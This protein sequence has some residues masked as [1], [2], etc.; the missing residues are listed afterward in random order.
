[1]ERK[2][3]RDNFGT[4]RLMRYGGGLEASFFSLAE[5]E[6]QGLGE[7]GTLP[8]CIKV[9]LE[10][11][12]RN[13]DGVQVTPEHVMGLAKWGLSGPWGEIP[14]MPA[15]VVLQDFTGVP[16]LVDLAAMREA[17]KEMG[18]DPARINPRIPCD[19]VIDHSVQVDYFNRPDALRLNEEK[20]F[21]RNQERYAFLKWGSGAFR[22]FRVMP[23]A[24]G[25][26]HQVN[27]EYLSTVVFRDEA[28]ALVY[29]DSCVGTDSHTPM[30]NGV[31]VLAWGV[32]GV[33]AE[34]A[35]L[36]QPIF[37]P[38][39][40]VVGFRLTGR[41]R[42]GVTATDLV[43]WIT[44][45]CRERGVVGK[46][47]EFGGPGVDALSVA[48]RATIANM[49]PEQGCT[50]SF[51]PVDEKTL[52]YLR[53]TGRPEHLVDLVERYTKEQGLFRTHDSPPPRYTETLDLDLS[54]VGPAV[55]GPKR[56]QDLIRLEDVARDFGNRLL[57]SPGPKGLGLEERDLSREAEIC[58]GPGTE[59]ITHGAVVIAAITSCTNTGNPSVMIGAGLLAKKAVERGLQV[60]KTV[61]TS[62]APGSRVVTAY[63]EK[64]G[65]LP[66]L[67]ALGF[68]LVGYGCTTCIGNSGPLPPD[69]ARAVEEQDLVACAVLSGNRNFEGRINPLV[70]AAFLASPPLVVAYAIAGSIAKDLT[71]EPLGVDREGREVFLRDIWPT[72]ADI[73]KV[74]LSS[75]EPDMFREQYR[76]IWAGP[77]PWRRIHAVSSDLYPWQE[78][79][80]YVRLPPFFKD[81]STGPAPPLTPIL[82][83]RVLGLFGDS[84][85]TD[86]ISPAGAIAPDSPAGLYLASA[87]VPS[88]AWNT[89]GSR[90]GNHEVM[91]RGTFANIR[92]RNLLVPGREGNVTVHHGSGE[93]MS[94]FDAAR[95]YEEEGV[96]LLIIAGREYGTGSSR[97]WA[98]KGPRLL[99]VRAVLAESYERIHRSNLV[100]MGILPL[101]FQ[102][103][104]SAQSLGLRGHESYDILL[105]ED[106][107]PGSRVRI[108]VSTP[109][110]GSRS[111]EALARI[112]TP[113]EVGYYRCGGILQAVL[114]DMI[115]GALDRDGGSVE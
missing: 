49:A 73:E 30:V 105:E 75:L 35:M 63:L 70:R 16:A 68:G 21:E 42:D 83:A 106:P 28:R 60:K 86:H 33:E 94:F 62:L 9:L 74:M 3:V 65:L 47:V 46:F 81:L 103:G 61:K 8:Y 5:M 53:M 100:G 76:S 14:F 102:P 112:D 22:N 23:P 111:F 31:G 66:Y 97:D 39:P 54:I 91:M 27:L 107:A 29:P 69:V 32:G 109:G 58:L 4:L 98:A 64:A 45:I 25:I 88:E 115:R 59:R 38:V 50:A 44:R 85:T 18:G 37:L 7:I 114:R 12:L 48:D 26:V 77:E 57:E 110:E 19:L 99:G 79:S 34:A 11:A 40:R 15:R 1:M 51:F 36:G 104:Q 113:V 87:G 17:M 80:T 52:D 55:S 43:L 82:G 92:I 71:R 72:N 56:P 90:R 89:Y 95:R 101:Q 96:P 78:D 93:L 6:R 20:E 108:R 13:E 10:S 84:V 24:S 2:G 67:E 41:L